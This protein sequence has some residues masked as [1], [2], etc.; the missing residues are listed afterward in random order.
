MKKAS[1]V[2]ATLIMLGAAGLA[3]A[4]QESGSSNAKMTGWVVDE[5]CGARVANEHGSDCAKKCVQGG[6]PVV[7]VDDKDQSVLKVAN[8]DALKSHAGEHVAVSGSVEKGTLTV[9]NVSAAS[10]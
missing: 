6:Q 8:Q 9:Q 5:K 7:F 2:F 10:K 1:A 3:F 4:R